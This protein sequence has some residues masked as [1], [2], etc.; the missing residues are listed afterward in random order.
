MRRLAPL[1]DVQAA[2]PQVLSRG[3]FFFADNA[4]N[5]VDPAGRAL[6]RQQARQDAG[7]ALS[8]AVLERHA[9]TELD[10]ILPRL[11]QREII[12]PVDDGYRFQIELVRCWVALEPRSTS[13]ILPVEEAT[14][15]AGPTGSS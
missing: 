13:L 6:L 2:V 9:T 11:I 10:A 14:A 4:R 7:C 15:T 5:Q 3:S 8:R 12:V 1:I